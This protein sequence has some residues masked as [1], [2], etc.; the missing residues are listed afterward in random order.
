MKRKYVQTGIAC[1]VH[2]AQQDPGE[3]LHFG[4][5]AAVHKPASAPF[6]HLPGVLRPGLAMSLSQV[7]PLGLRDIISRVILGTSHSQW[8]E[9]WDVAV[10]AHGSL[11]YNADVQV[12]THT[13]TDTHTSIHRHRCMCTRRCMHTDTQT[14]RATH[15]HT[16]PLWPETLCW[17]V[18]EK[19]QDKTEDSQKPLAP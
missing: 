11:L 8:G 7:R 6:S 14:F 4:A 12:R 5:D 1:T 2:L 15:A 17:R 19:K 16:P 18:I 9:A 13:H 3:N 10:T